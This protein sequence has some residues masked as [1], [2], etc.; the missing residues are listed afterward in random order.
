MNRP[1][2]DEQVLTDVSGHKRAVMSPLLK[3]SEFCATCHKA[4]APPALNDYKFLR[5][6]SAYDEWQQSGAST[7]TVAPYYRREQQATCNAC[8]MPQLASK[9]DWLM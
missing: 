4:A 9:N 2:T 3:K 7:H 6:F 8:H 5:G 1:Y